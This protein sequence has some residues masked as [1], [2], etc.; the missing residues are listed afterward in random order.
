M[1]SFSEFSGPSGPEGRR[2]RA[3]PSIEPMEVRGLLSGVTPTFALTQDWGSGFQATITLANAQPSP[4]ADWTLSFSYSASISSIWDA[5]IVSHV[6]NQYVVRGAGWDNTIPGSGSVS[7]GFVGSPGNTAAT[8]TN[9]VL[10]G[11]ALGGGG[12]VTPPVV[13]TVSVGNASINEPT[14][15]GSSLAFAVALSAPTT[16]TV[17]VHYAT[18][19]GTAKAGV[20]YT[21]TSGTLTFAPGQTSQSV[22]VPILVD[23]AL[24]ATESFG[25]ALSSPS[26]AT[27][28]TAR[29][30]GTIVYSP[31]PP[32]PPPTSGPVTFQVTSDW[33]S[34]FDGQINFKN[35][36]AAAWTNWVVQFDFPGQITS[37]WD[38]VLYSHVGNHYVFQN[39]SY[40]GA[41]APG[42]SGSFG[43]G[44]SPGNVTV[45][46]TNMVVGS[47][48][49]NP[50]PPV[51]A[52][53]AAWTAPGQPVTI[54][55]LANDSDPNGDALTVTSAGQGQHGTVAVNPDSTVTYTPAAGFT[56]TDSF[57]YTVT[58]SQGMSATATVTVTVSAIHWPARVFAPYVDA[59]AYPA[60]DFVN[61]AQTQ[62]VKYF[63]LAFVVA[64]TAN[65]N[66]PSWGG[67]TPYDVNGGA[68]DMALRSQ[69]N[70]VRGLGGDVAVSFGGE[71]GTELA[72][73]ITNVGSLQ[74]AYQSVINAYGLTRI[75][76]DIEGGA[77]ADHASIDRRSQ[78][79][80]GLQQAAAAAGKTLQVTFTLPVLPTGLTADGLY[81][82]QSALKYGVKITTVNV[83]A[84]DFGDNAAPNPAGQMGTYAIDSATSTFNQLQTLYGTSETPAQLWAMI[85]VTPML[86]VND[87]PSEV[88]D[89]AAAQQLLAF[90]QQEGIGEIAMW[91]LNR[92]AGASDG[93]VQ[94]PYA[95]SKIFGPFSS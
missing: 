2:R 53:S 46:P 32:P 55:V 62:G 92:D 91:S 19:D 72:Q 52:N 93:I 83:M 21:S 59:T 63:N 68:F 64:D 39:A 44:G 82:V 95:F 77:V 25:L 28:A 94:Q 47:G 84:M 41:V 57:A 69:I 42:G 74:A 35:T 80:A 90:A 76:F 15:G 70:Q 54:A 75:D 33:G 9:Y 51:A 13:P 36:G 18:V 20:D 5:T 3:R 65:G 27:L 31:P 7:F 48:V 71:N 12:G 61:A 38:A 60:F 8:P 30:T 66:V 17:T 24:A 10:N 81:V 16:S 37:A 79:I 67:F 56:G 40:D 6:G 23:K 45:G 87:D 43:F 14:A 34:G 73:A 86:G 88:F 26:N 22:S 78:A 29:G 1:P 4:V 58:D 49:A 85:G 89:Q 11:Q 50:R